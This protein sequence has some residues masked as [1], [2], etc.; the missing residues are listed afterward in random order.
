[1]VYV[2]KPAPSLQ[3]IASD[4]FETFITSSNNC[5]FLAHQAYVDLLICVVDLCHWSQH[6]RLQQRT[7]DAKVDHR[8]NLKSRVCEPARKHNCGTGPKTKLFKIYKQ[9]H[10]QIWIWKKIFIL[11]KIPNSENHLAFW[12]WF[13]T[14]IFIQ[15]ASFRSIGFSKWNLFFKI[16]F[17]F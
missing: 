6:Y 4:W 7:L 2:V 10:K 14:M 12:K 1:M 13:R 11:K 9:F 5:L 3:T 16:D 8:M 15:R 17:D